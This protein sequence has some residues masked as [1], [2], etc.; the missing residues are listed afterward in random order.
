MASP[1]W[2]TVFLDV[3][4]DRWP[5]AVEFWA[6]VTGCD[7]SRRRGENDQFLTLL[8]TQGHPWLKMQAITETGARIHLDLDHPDRRAAVEASRSLGGRHAWTYEG[9]AVMRSPGGLLYCHTLPD[10]EQPHIDRTGLDAIAD[11]VCLDI[12]PRLWDVEVEFWRALTGRPLE[13]GM[14]PEFAFLGDPDPGGP[15]R[16]LLQRLDD[17][18]PRVSAHLD[19]AVR[20]RQAQVRHHESLGARRLAAFER[21]TQMQAPSG[22]VYC[23]TERDPGTGRIR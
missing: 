12:P 2:I 9:V 22:H 6:T 7:V 13:T 16:I 3:P 21:W 19:F 18:A 23:L 11:Q 5:S 8:P 17:D 10:G 4:A 1:T 14:R 20:D 15:P